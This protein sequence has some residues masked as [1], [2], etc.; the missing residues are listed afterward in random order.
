MP[1]REQGFRQRGRILQRNAD[2]N[3]QHLASVRNYKLR[4]A[5]TIDERA[6]TVSGLYAGHARAC[7]D[8]LARNLEPGNRAMDIVG[9]ATTLIDIMPVHP[10]GGDFDQYLVRAACR[11]GN[12]AWP[13]NLWAAGRADVDSQLHGR[14]WMPAHDVIG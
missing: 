9:A 13:Q 6:N 10:G 4:I 14:V 1:H 7:G 8:N 3:G 5:A 11:D 12:A 2:R